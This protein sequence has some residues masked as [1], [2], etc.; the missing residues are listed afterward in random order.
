MTQN[1]ILLLLTALICATLACSMFIG[2]PDYLPGTIPISTEAVESLK[3]QME[4]AALAGAQTGTITLQI[5]EEQ[6]TSS[7]AFK[8]VAQE[9]PVFQEPQIYLR[10]G[11]M[12]IYGKVVR[13]FFTANILV[14]LFVNVDEFGQPKIEILTAD[15][16]P[17]PAPEGL[18]SSLTALITEAYTGTLGPVATGFRIDTI[19]IADGTMTIT[20]Q[21]N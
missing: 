4:S 2:G 8:L 7:I 20:G 3:E 19:I 21:I 10:N 9:K 11:Q 1:R 5:T 14:A 13:G 15:F 12:Q 16:G 17:F 18:K 6:I